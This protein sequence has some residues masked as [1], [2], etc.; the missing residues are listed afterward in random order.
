MNAEQGPDGRTDE[1]AGEPGADITIDE[2]FAALIPALSPDELAQLERSL[3]APA[4]C[5]DALIV[6]ATTKI[7]LDGHNRLAICR[8]H[9][10]PFRVELREFPDR[11]RR[12][13][14]C[15]EPARAP[16]PVP[17]S[18]LVLPG[19]ALSGRETSAWR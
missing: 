8:R 14:P 5:R 7:L 15:P 13:V 9:G 17:G 4:G 16:E 1:R 2:G 18:R 6:W 19:Q 3:L 10:I 11:G 12:G